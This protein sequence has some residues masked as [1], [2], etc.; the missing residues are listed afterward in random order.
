MNRTKWSM[1]LR[2]NHEVAELVLCDQDGERATRV[3][4]GINQLDALLMGW[5]HQYGCDTVLMHMAAMQQADPIVRIVIERWSAN[6]SK[7]PG[8]HILTPSETQRVFEL[9]DKPRPASIRALRRQMD[10]QV[11]MVRTIASVTGTVDP[12][13]IAQ[14]VAMRLE[15]DGQYL[16]W[17]RGEIH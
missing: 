1:K 10:F 4:R 8:W 6:D 11:E 16:R 14:I 12:S 15:I 9:A 7:H 3:V 2:G 13:T 17:I 5:E